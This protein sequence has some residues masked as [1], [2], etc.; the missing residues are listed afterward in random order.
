MV[1]PDGAFVVAG[2]L[3]GDVLCGI[4]EFSM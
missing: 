1:A 2:G 4:Q 3:D